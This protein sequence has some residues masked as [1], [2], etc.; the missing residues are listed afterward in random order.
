MTF[1][2]SSLTGHRPPRGL[3]RRFHKLPT[4]QCRNLLGQLEIA[5]RVTRV[6]SLWQLAES[7]VVTIPVPIS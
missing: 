5:G 7:E 1:S 2:S 6:D 4:Q 3:V